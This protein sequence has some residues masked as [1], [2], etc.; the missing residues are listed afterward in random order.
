MLR[1][2]IL[3][4]V[5]FI[6]CYIMEE[7]RICP[8]SHW[9][10]YP[11]PS[12]NWRGHCCVSLNLKGDNWIPRPSMEPMSF[13]VLMFGY[14]DQ[15]S[16]IADFYCLS[17]MTLSSH[18]SHSFLNSQGRQLD[19]MSFKMCQL[20]EVTHQIICTFTIN[21]SLGTTSCNKE[22]YWALEIQKLPYNIAT[23]WCVWCVLK[24]FFWLLHVWH[25]WHFW[26]QSTRASCSG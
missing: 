21:T 1:W 25:F 26:H 10:Y 20:F 14:Q 24:S 23:T 6:L 2:I 8:G 17:S 16:F 3:W 19:P 22:P 13:Y 15:D 7:Y 18:S 4:N 5:Y 11:T 9:Y 12:P